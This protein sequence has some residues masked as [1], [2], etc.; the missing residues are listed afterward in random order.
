M[1][2]NVKEY[3]G[4]YL[5]EAKAIIEKLDQSSIYKIIEILVDVRRNKGR[6]FILGIGGSAGNAGHAVNDFRKLAGME[7]YAQTDNVS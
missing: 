4:S 5:E 6:L 2:D 7:C 1:G 3:I